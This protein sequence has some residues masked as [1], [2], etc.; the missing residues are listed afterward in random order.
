MLHSATKSLHQLRSGLR[1][2]AISRDI[3]LA[4][5]HRRQSGYHCAISGGLEVPLP[6]RYAP[7][8]STGS[9]DRRRRLAALAGPPGDLV[10]GGSLI[11]AAGGCGGD[12]VLIVLTSP[13]HSPGLVSCCV[14]AVCPDQDA[15][16][17]TYDDNERLM[18]K[19]VYD[20]VMYDHF[21]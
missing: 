19:V 7:I 1:C 11:W 17:L 10:S 8:F 4:M 20:S 18:K 16:I 5:G 6:V 14:L 21:L 2:P 9:A 12:T 3:L 15:R 13:S